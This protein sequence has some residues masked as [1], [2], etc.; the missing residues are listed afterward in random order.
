MT[1]TPTLMTPQPIRIQP[2]LSPIKRAILIVIGSGAV[3]LGVLGLILP[4][5]PATIFFII[6]TGCYARSSDRLY[7]W[8]VT[9]PWLQKP[10]K[11]ATEFRR[12]G[13]MPLYAKWIAQSAVWFSFALLV[14]NERALFAQIA[15][16]V[17]ALATTIAM[18]IIPVV[19]SHRARIW[20]LDTRDVLGQLWRGAAAGLFAGAVF[21][22]AACV[23]IKFAA[24]LTGH[25]A[26]IDLT[27]FG[28]I[29]AIS[30]PAGAGVGMLY[31]AGRHILPAN[32]WVRGFAFGWWLCFTVGTLAY[33]NPWVHQAF[34]QIAAPFAWLALALVAAASIV[35]GLLLSL[36]F[37]Q[38]ER[39]K[40]PA[41]G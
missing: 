39:I 14:L 15:V 23:L 19:K 31:A 28:T 30:V 7:T 29:A 16:F 27:A 12:T 11:A 20:S 22:V 21:A 5:M 40:A 10:M 34:M 18:V 4:G 9:R 3:G 6:A 25:A 26:P 13:A 1:S 32:Q 24:N 2:E 33:V 41:Q 37:G 17:T 38:L 8:L 35:C 36:S